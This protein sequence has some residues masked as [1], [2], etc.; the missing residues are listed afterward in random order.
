M[1]DLESTT[2]I[3]KLTLAAWKSLLSLFE[4]Q[5]HTYEMAQ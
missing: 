3:F 2:K 5:N 4:V 1:I